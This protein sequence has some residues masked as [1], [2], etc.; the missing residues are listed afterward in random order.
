[1]SAPLTRLGVPK[2]WHEDRARLWRFARSIVSP[3]TLLLAPTAA[4]G[5][6][7][8]PRDRGCVLAANH[9][10]GIDHPLIGTFVPG[11]TYF[12]AKSELFEIPV[13][14]EALDWMG[15]ISIRRGESDRDALRIARRHLREGDVVC[16]HI[17][18]T[19]QRLGYPGPIHPGG[20]MIAMQ[21]GAPVVPLG[22]DTFGWSPANRRLCAL[23]FGEPIELDHL[24]RKRAGYEEAGELVRGEIVRLWR[25]AVEAAAVG[26]PP[27]LP[28]GTR[29]DDPV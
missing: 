11:I 10:S 13:L 19:R 22:L 5:V 14:G 24:P 8:I 1:M 23:V 17:E 20:L 9:F 7:R 25:Q 3:I 2:L 29:R 12:L 18:G 28:D 16:V 21:E 27:E 26:L 4:Y 15:V 6:E